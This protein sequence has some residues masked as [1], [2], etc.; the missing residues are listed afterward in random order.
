MA[1]NLEYKIAF[2]GLNTCSKG[3]SMPEVKKYIAGDLGAESGRV[4]L[5]SVSAS[6]LVLEEIH[7]FGNGP[8]EEAGSLR[9]DFNRLFSEIKTGIHQLNLDRIFLTMNH[10]ILG[11]EIAMDSAHAVHVEECVK[12]LYSD[13]KKIGGASCCHVGVETGSVDVLGNQNR[14]LDRI[15]IEVQRPYNALM[16]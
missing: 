16:V 2:L 14:T 4:M 5:G 11:L 1:Q 12:D 9:W 10:D 6:K 3:L 7:R 13:E 8:I 15:D